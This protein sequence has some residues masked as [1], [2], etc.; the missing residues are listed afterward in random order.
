M[1]SSATNKDAPTQQDV[2]IDLPGETVQCWRSSDSIRVILRKHRDVI[3]DLNLGEGRTYTVESTKSD[4]YNARDKKLIRV[5][6]RNVVTFKD[7]ERLHLWVTRS[8][9]GVLI[10]RCGAEVMLKLAPNHLDAHQYD[11][12]AKTK[13]APIILTLGSP[14]S[15]IASAPANFKKLDTAPRSATPPPSSAPIGEQ[16]S[17]VC[18]VEATIKGAPAS[19]DEF[20][21]KGGGKS[22]FAAIDPNDVATRNWLLGQLAGTVAYAKD[23]WSWLRASLDTRTHQGFRLVT[24][25]IHTV[26]GKARIYFSGFSQYNEVFGRGGFGSAHERIVNIFAGVGKTASSF[27]AVAKGVTGSFKGNALISFVF[28]AATSIAEWHEDM[29]KDEIDLIAALLM[30]VLKAIIA[31]A[32][33]VAIV[34]GVIFV[35]MA[36][37]GA[38]IPV[39]LVGVT[40]I[41]AGFVANL[42]VENSDKELGRSKIGTP[43]NN[44]GLTAVLAPALRHARSRIEANWEL[45]VRK[46][47]WDYADIPL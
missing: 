23:N 5:G 25:K 4:F 39:L 13:P 12:A 3:F 28:G 1:S 9:E 37:F 11:D 18:V 17:V 27:A 44:D 19:L 15:S 20:L 21:K 35:V 6:S 36:L 30:S 7:G 2:C 16:C 32:L 40:T 26:R 43:E 38:A 42:I 34:A 10:L 14:N 31:A 33:T 22:R 46:Y 8:F 45:L 47:P 41:M 29:Q 24:A